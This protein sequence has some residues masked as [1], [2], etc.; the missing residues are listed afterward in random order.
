M[1]I[2]TNCFFI[3]LANTFFCNWYHVWILI[4]SI[5]PT[6]DAD[7]HCTHRWNL[8]IVRLVS[9]D[10]APS[11]WHPLLVRC[12]IGSIWK[13]SL[14]TMWLCHDYC[15]IYYIY[16]LLLWLP[17]APGAHCDEGTVRSCSDA[18][19]RGSPAVSHTRTELYG[20]YW[21]GVG[22]IYT[23]LLFFFYMIRS[24]SGC[25]WY[26]RNAVRTSFGYK[27]H[28]DVLVCR[29][30]VDIGHNGFETRFPAFDQQG[31]HAIDFPLHPLRPL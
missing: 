18:G 29:F 13:C 12:H 30:R 11:R 1:L 7:A 19:S 14:Q 16:Q 22:E 6:W 28:Y 21:T 25:I 17:L 26:W 8:L 2:W 15:A 27:C 9:S 31:N 10:L 23:C 3:S 20:T 5:M 4:V 24:L